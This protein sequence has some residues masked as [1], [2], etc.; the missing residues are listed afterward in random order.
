MFV[1]CESDLGCFHLAREV[2]LWQSANAALDAGTDVSLSG[3]R[4]EAAKM[5]AALLPEEPAADH[6]GFR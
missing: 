2:L 4:F 6:C 3:E 5:E 1:G